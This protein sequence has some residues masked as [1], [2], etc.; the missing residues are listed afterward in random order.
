MEEIIER[1]KNNRLAQIALIALIF[2]LIFV[3]Y[4][5]FK[6]VKSSRRELPCYNKTIRLLSPLNEK[7]FLKIKQVF[8]NYCL[9]L[10]V[11]VKPP[12]Y[13]RENLLKEIAEG[14]IPDLVYIDNEFIEENRNVFKEYEGKKILSRNYP[15]VT[16]ILNKNKLLNYPVVFDNLVLFSNE[17]YLDILGIFN[18]PNN[19]E[20]LINLISTIKTTP[21]LLNVKPIALGT[22]N[23]IENF[24]EIFLTLHKNYNSADYKRLENFFKTIAFYTQFADIKS[25]LY[26]WSATNLNSFEEF[27]RGNVVFVFGFYSDFEKIKDINP[28][29]NFKINSFPKFKNKIEQTNFIRVYSFVVPKQGKYQFAWKALEILDDNYE[30]FVKDLNLLPVRKDIYEKLEGNK[31]EIAKDLLTGSTFIEFN[32]PYAEDLLKDVINK[33][34]TDKENAKI[35]FIRGQFYKIFKK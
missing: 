4:N 20:D 29:L 18:P 30:S 9:Y 1:I 24:Y 10:Q 12:D 31:K 27:G 25:P 8:S 35:T 17:K 13:I 19:F 33:W 11:D 15:E 5:F 21:Q 6:L 34:L 16:L 2:V 22:S 7:K 14:K 28:R 3:F 26:S 32:R 23:N